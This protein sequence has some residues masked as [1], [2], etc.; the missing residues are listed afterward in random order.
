MRGVSQR[1]YSAGCPDLACVRLCHGGRA[2]LLAFTKPFPDPAITV[3][4]RLARDCLSSR[5][6]MRIE[7]VSHALRD[8]VAASRA[9]PESAAFNYEVELIA[10]R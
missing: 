1:G 5:R 7:D 3:L 10:D 6:T 2:R 9:P 4:I 8:A